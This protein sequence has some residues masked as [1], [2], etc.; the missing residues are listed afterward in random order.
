VHPD[1]IGSEKR[2]HQRRVSPPLVVKQ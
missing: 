2:I 1:S